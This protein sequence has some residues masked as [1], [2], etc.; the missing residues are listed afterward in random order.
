[1]GTFLRLGIAKVRVEACVW[2]KIGDRIVIGPRLTL[3]F[4]LGPEFGFR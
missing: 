3:A 1:M 4:G 2:V